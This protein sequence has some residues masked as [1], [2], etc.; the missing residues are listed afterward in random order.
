VIAT[1]ATATASYLAVER[2][3]MRLKNRRPGPPR[4]AAAPASARA[5]SQVSP[6]DP[7]ADELDAAQE[8][9]HDERPHA[10]LALTHPKIVATAIATAATPDST[11]I[12]VPATVASASGTSEKD[13]SASIARRNSAR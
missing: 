12:D 6:Q 2:P 5:P 7:H 9:Q 4:T 1:V 3:L 11:A 13:A 10:R 8:Q